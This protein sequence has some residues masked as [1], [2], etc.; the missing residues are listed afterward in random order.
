[1]LKRV[2]K[3]L[4]TIRRRRAIGWGIAVFL[5]LAIFYGAFF[6]PP[7]SFPADS[8]VRVAQG[9]SA[10]DIADELK[11]R[12]FIRSALVFKA[13]MKL[14]GD[15]S[16]IA[17]EYYFANGQ[18]VISVARRMTKGEYDVEPI[19]ITVPE[20]TSVRGIT[21]LLKAVPEF[22]EEKFFELA[23]EKE[24]R[25]FPDTYFILP[26]EDPA[27]VVKRFEDNFK[28][29]VSRAQVAV[30][31]AAFG[32]PFDEVIIMASL[33]EEEANNSHDRR[34]IA[35]ILWRRIEQG[36]PLQVDAVFPYIIGKGSHQLTKTDLQVNNP[37]NT[38]IN[39]GLPPAPITN[40]GLNAILDAVTPTDTDYLFY[41]ADQSGTTYY[42]V[43]YEQHLQNRAKH[44]GS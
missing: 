31:V 39:K 29:Q 14:F 6:A 32:K 19:K 16:L 26:G 28:A 22:D 43:T 10:G 27:L 36:I 8:Y 1:M 34:L 13:M 41:L 37:Y 21:E 7:L 24:G 5:S 18:G 44:L 4:R 40:P 11:E 9:M 25:M 30:A 2:L 15:T 20:G 38:Y 23:K 33:L 3:R 42:S 12:S 35:G 17:G